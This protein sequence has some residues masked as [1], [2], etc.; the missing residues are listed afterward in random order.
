MRDGVVVRTATSE[1]RS[2]I[3]ELVLAAFSSVDHD[4]RQEVDIVT[5]TWRLGVTPFDLEL[6]AVEDHAIVG[7]VLAAWGDLGGQA[8]VAVAPLAVSS[9]RQRQGTGSALMNELVR[10]AEAAALPLIVLLGDPRYYE[11]FGFEPSGPLDISY[12]VVGEDN[13]HFQVR[14]YAHYDRTLR[15]TFAYCWEMEDDRV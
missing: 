13:P 14:R 6:V 1:D 15:G 8:V 7:H 5:A 9:S 2:A 10:R 11:R 4:G 12:P 3:L